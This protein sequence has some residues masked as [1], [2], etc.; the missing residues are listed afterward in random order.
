MNDSV[1]FERKRKQD[2]SNLRIRISFVYV[3]DVNERMFYL[4]PLIKKK[5][6]TK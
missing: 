3:F 6:T 1:K 4:C 5:K 2:Q